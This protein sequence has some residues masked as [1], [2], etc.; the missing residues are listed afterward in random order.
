MRRRP[1]AV[2]L[3]VD[4]GGHVAERYTGMELDPERILPKPRR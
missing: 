3:F 4:G 1:D 2:V